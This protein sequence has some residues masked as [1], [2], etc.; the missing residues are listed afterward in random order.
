MTLPVG[1][2][3][4]HDR[5]NKREEARGRNKGGDAGSSGASVNPTN[6]S[7]RSRGGGR[8]DESGRTLVKSNELTTLTTITTRERKKLTVTNVGVE[9]ADRVIKS[10]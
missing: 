3:E 9:Q 5:G 6:H 7:V 1:D 10:G 4:A 2:D 8:T